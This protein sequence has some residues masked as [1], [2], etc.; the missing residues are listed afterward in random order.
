MLVLFTDTDSDFTPESAKQYGYNLISMPYIMDDKTI[1]PYEDADFEKNYDSHEFYEKLRKGALPTTAG[2][3]PEKYKSYFEPF[4]ENGD[5]ILY[6]HFATAMSGTFGAMNLA[7]S[8]LKEKYPERKF[9]EIDTKGITILSYAIAL[10]IGEMYKNGAD[11]SEILAWADK[12]VQKHAI[13]F[14][15]DDLKF[16]ARSGRVTNFSAIM[17]N[18]IGIHPILTMGADGMM[19]ALGKAQGRKKTLN[20][21][22]DMI[23]EKEDGIASHRVVIGHCDIP[24]IAANVADMLKKRFGENLDIVTVDVNPTAGCH[25]G[26]DGLGIVFHS[27][28]R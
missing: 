13:Y 27:K 1:Y 12:E 22:M 4:F 28:N 11:I 18:I 23:A 2:L 14:Y 20:K 6:V 7:V 17:G 3:S 25:C 16:F 9:Y 19:T 26:P 8:E 15:V 5:D 10:E 24:D 21:I